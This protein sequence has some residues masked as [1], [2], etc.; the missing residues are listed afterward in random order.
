VQNTAISSKL[1]RVT[2]R[3]RGRCE[4]SVV[5]A[6]ISLLQQDSGLYDHLAPRLKLKLEGDLA[7]VS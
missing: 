5:S 4:L 2:S 1:R 7:N 6:M 3:R